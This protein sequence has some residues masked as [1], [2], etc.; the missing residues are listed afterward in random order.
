[1]HS[2]D[3]AEP[4]AFHSHKHFFQTP[5]NI[6]HILFQQQCLSHETQIVLFIYFSINTILWAEQETQ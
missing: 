1:M 5:H 3:N 4:A 6:N 2:R